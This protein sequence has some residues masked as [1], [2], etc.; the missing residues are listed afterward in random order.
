LVVTRPTS[1]EAILLGCPLLLQMWIHERFASVDPGRTS[2]STSR[3]HRSS[4]TPH[5]GFSVVSPEGNDL[6]L[7]DSSRYEFCSLIHLTFLVLCS[8]FRL[9]SN[10]KRPTRTSLVR[11]TRWSMPRSGW[12]HTLL[13]WSLPEHHRGSRPCAPETRRAG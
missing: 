9:G 4:E 8:T 10:R 2:R 11:S 6:P 1:R 7:R 12:H 5:H 13:P 3:R